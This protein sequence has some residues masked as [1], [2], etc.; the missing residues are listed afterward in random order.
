MPKIGINKKFK[1]IFVKN[2]KMAETLK[3]DIAKEVNIS[4]RRNDSFRINLEVSDSTGVMDLAD[5]AYTTV[6]E[7]QA[8]MTIINSSGERV[9]SVYS[10]YWK[11][12][13]PASD[14]DHPVDVTPTSSTEGHFSGD[15][16][17][18][19]IDLTDQTGSGTKARIMIPHAY[20]GFQSGDYKYDL[21]IRKQ[22]TGTTADEDVAE[23]TTWLYGT[24]T[25]N[26]DITQV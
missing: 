14:S 4:A 11:G 24:F 23:Y 3:A 10:Y 22:T 20:M 19:G 26:A 9:L 5:L 8:K 16:T 18:Q 21:Q 13:T 1:I 7:Y 17:N 25:L 2:N 12:I 15:S 6:P